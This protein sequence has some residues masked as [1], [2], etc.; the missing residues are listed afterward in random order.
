MTDSPTDTS[1]IG[2]LVILSSDGGGEVDIETESESRES[3]READTAEQY[4]KLASLADIH[5]RFAPHPPTS[6]VEQEAVR[7]AILDLAI[8]LSSFMPPSR[9]AVLAFTKLEEAAFWAQAAMVQ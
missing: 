6:D 9:Q 7:L 1:R 5:K 2:N 8:L 4:S 3:E